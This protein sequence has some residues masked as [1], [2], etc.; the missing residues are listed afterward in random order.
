MNGLVSAR[1]DLY[2]ISQVA[3]ALRLNRYQVRG[4]VQ[5]L[6]LTLKSDPARPTGM[7][8]DSSDVER[9]KAASGRETD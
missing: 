7:M 9:I 3:R 5:G 6:G 2:S 4:I 8:L 1:P